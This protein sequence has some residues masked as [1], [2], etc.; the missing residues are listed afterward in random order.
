MTSSFQ[1][2]VLKTSYTVQVNREEFLQLLK[3]ERDSREL[4]LLYALQKLGLFDVDYDGHFDAYIYFSIEKSEDT[5]EL[6]SKIQATLREHK[7]SPGN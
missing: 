7:L 3:S 2:E 6:W 1:R 5:E 4:P